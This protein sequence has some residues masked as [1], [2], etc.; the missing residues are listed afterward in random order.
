[1][2]NAGV[3]AQLQLRSSRR[4]HA[5]YQRHPHP[6]QLCSRLPHPLQLCSRHLSRLLVTLLLLLFQSRLLYQSHTAWAAVADF[7]AP[8][9]L[10]RLRHS[11]APMVSLLLVVV[12]L[13]SLLRGCLPSYPLRL[14]L[15]LP[16][17][18]HNFNLRHEMAHKFNLD[19]VGPGGRCVFPISTAWSPRRRCCD[20]PQ[21]QLLTSFVYYYEVP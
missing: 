8:L 5:L 13:L 11:V 4:L 19:R 14:I 10:L 2:R 6:L 17:G 21:L 15:L 12:V 3:V 7:M 1:M 9:Q 20:A 18:Q 16:R